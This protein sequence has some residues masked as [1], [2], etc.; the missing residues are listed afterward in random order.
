M[1]R[2]HLISAVVLV[3]GA[4]SAFPQDAPDSDGFPGT[5]IGHIP[6]VEIPWNRLYDLPELYGHFDRLVE[7]WP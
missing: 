2:H 7:T 6:C 3:L 4:A 5:P 1:M